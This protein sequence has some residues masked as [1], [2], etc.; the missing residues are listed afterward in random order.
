[1]SNLL[2]AESLAVPGNYPTIQVALDAAMNNDWIQVD[3]GTYYENVIVPGIRIDIY[4]SDFG[5]TIIDGGAAASAITV[6]PHT[7]AGVLTRFSRLTIRNAAARICSLGFADNKSP[8]PLP[9]LPRALDDNCQL[10]TRSPTVS[11]R[12]ASRR[13]SR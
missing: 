5:E 13:A 12:N 9:A 11:G 8:L 3:P 2:Q 1:M 7:A 10:H 6:L 4:G